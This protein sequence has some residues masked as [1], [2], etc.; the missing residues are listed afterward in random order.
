[1]TAVGLGLQEPAV[2]GQVITFYSYKGGTGRSMALANSAWLLAQRSDGE[3]KTLMVEWDLEAPGLHKYF[4]KR[5]GDLPTA[6]PTRPGLIDLFMF[7][8][9]ET[10]AFDELPDS[11]REQSTRNLVESLDIDSYISGTDLPGLYL[12]KAGRL[13]HS[14][15]TNV[16][17]F[18]W[19]NFYQRAPWA[20]VSLARHLSQRFRYVLVDSRTGLTDTSGICTSLLPEKLV[21]V[22]TPNAQSMEGISELI[23]RAV[24]YRQSTDDLRPLVVYPLP[25]RIENTDPDE[26]DAWRAGNTKRDLQGW[27]P[28]FEKTIA[29]I[30]GLEGCN[31]SAYFDEV[32]IRHQ[33]YYAYGEKVAVKLE[34][35]TEIDSMPKSYERFVDWLVNCA[36]PWEDPAKVTAA[37]EQRRA[38][39]L[40]R[41]A[42]QL[43]MALDSDE[44]RKVARQ[45]F[46]RLV[47]I[48]G[49]TEVGEHARQIAMIDDFAPAT[50]PATNVINKFRDAGLLST[51]VRSGSSAVGSSNSTR[52]LIPRA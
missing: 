7:L 25:S 32:Q 40:G 37:A 20:I 1:M 50:I 43:F 30:Y 41:R 12:L 38:K 15:A 27:E 47:K 31:L 18:R 17:Q 22:F 34:R 52:S 46:M 39:S 48:L 19:D 5:E 8:A 6:D 2:P 4:P 10:R 26:R 14:Y 42:E 9:E 45:V 33:P 51:S 29:N 13:D 24:E 21:V 3:Y 44:E 35:G 49:E 28:Y 36:S 23:S 11:A 16:N